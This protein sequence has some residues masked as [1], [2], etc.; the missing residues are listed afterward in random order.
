MRIYRLIADETIYVEDPNGLICYCRT[1]QG[2][3]NYLPNRGRPL[4]Y[5]LEVVPS[6][7][8]HRNTEEMI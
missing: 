7:I 3:P 2:Q 6:M 1:L 5:T 4:E 8:R